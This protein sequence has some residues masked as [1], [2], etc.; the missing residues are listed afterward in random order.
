MQRVYYIVF[1][2]LLCH[3][4]S[5]SQEKDS[6]T[7]GK[8]QNNVMRSSGRVINT[9]ARKAEQLRQSLSENDL[10]TA[11]TLYEELAE[12]LAEQGEYGKAENYFN[13]ALKIYTR[14]K[15]SVKTASVARSL[16]QV[17]EQQEK[18]AEAADKYRMAGETET[19]PA[20]SRL[21]FTDAKRVRHYDNPETQLD[22]IDSN[23]EIA[24]DEEILEEQVNL[25]RQ[26]AETS[27][28][29][30]DTTGAIQS[31]SQ[32][33]KIAGS[34]PREMV[35]LK[36]EAARVYESD[37]RIDEAIALTTAALDEATAIDDTDEIIAQTQHLA[38]LYQRKKEDTQAITLLEKAYQTAVTHGKTTAAREVVMALGKVYQ[39]Q[40]STQQSLAAY[41]RFLDDLDRLI[42]ADSS[43]FDARAFA[44]TEE[45][46]ARLESERQ[47]KDQLLLKTNR[48]NYVLFGSVIL[49]LVLLGWIVKSFYDIKLKN[50]KIALQSLRREMNPHFIF[51]SL[52][53]I[54]QFIAENNEREANTY[55]TSYSRL[56][57]ST[58]EMSSK[59][60]ITL[61]EELELLEKYLNLEHLRFL[62]TFDYT[63][64]V[65]PTIDTEH[66]WVPNMLIQPHVENAIWHG[67]RYKEEKGL[68][69]LSVANAPG[70]IKVIIDDNGIGTTQSRALKT[71]NQKLHDSRGLKNVRERIRLLN[72]LYR[73]DHSFRIVEKEQESGTRV[74]IYFSKQLKKQP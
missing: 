12:S 20:V 16:A 40:G 58:M 9:N 35:K 19:K 46:I 8:K 70:Y 74:T 24:E 13:S 72:K 57:R 66:T 29:A 55:L 18:Y 68:L 42:R 63:V 22:M 17:L 31:Y 65:D 39:E 41:H 59:D 15:N 33:I 67:L 71:H 73:Q 64:E 2:L 48:L 11:A 51:N 27:L 30:D 32:A 50:K 25:Y 52:N 26:R 3:C 38:G 36:T 7:Y 4:F 34:S 6:T 21:N 10:T 28:R 56:M 1:T 53:S 61:A 69:K 45:R 49:M 43:L 44:T 5:F 14:Q 60:F 23:L 54:N 37:N 47:L 62:D